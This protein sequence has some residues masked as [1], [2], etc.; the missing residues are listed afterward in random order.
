MAQPWTTV[1]WALGPRDRATLPPQ[2]RPAWSAACGAAR[3][4]WETA[5]ARATAAGH[6][7]A[8]AAGSAGE[9]S[10]ASL[11]GQTAAAGTEQASGLAPTSCPHAL[12]KTAH[13]SGRTAAAQAAWAACLSGKHHRGKRIQ[14]RRPCLWYTCGSNDEPNP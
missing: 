14:G 10:T 9:G 5:R 6:R 3:C 12:G 7:A 11:L 4:P 8:P 2:R 1:A 13:I